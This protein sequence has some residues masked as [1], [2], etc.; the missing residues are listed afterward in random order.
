LVRLGAVGYELAPARPIAELAE[1]DART[2]AAVVERAEFPRFLDAG[3]TSAYELAMAAIDK[4][5]AVSELAPE[6]V[7]CIVFATDSFKSAR[8]TMA[9]YRRLVHTRGF[10]RAYPV[11][12]SMSECAN[13]HAALDVAQSMSAQGRAD[14]LLLVTVDLARMV[15]PESRL[16]GEGVGVMSDAAA[17]CIVSPRLLDGLELV[18]VEKSIRTGLVGIERPLTPQQDLLARLET[19]GQLFERLFERASLQ[20]GNVTKIL[21]SNLGTSMLRNFLGDLGFEDR[22]LFTSNHQRMAH[23]LASDCLINLHDH[24]A[25]SEAAAGDVFI[26]YGLGPVTWG[27]AVLR[28]THSLSAV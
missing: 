22:Q 12:V 5:M 8:E 27:G 26:L 9:F 2:K 17:S 23:C 15:S 7:D 13:L 28:A 25:A 18:C 21:P 20:A 19:N 24:V 4:T 10:T 1:P 3:E 6:E 11:M 16:V 14:T